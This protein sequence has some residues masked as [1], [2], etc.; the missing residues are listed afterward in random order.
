MSYCRWS[1]DAFKSD[2]YVY[3]H[4]GGYWAIHVAGSRYVGDV[5]TL[6][7]P[8]DAK[9]P[10]QVEAFKASYDAQRKFF[11]A[12]AATAL[13]NLPHAGETFQEPT[14]GACADRI[15]ELV[16]L[17]YHVPAGVVEELRAEQAGLAA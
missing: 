15:E 2:L 10:A 6:A 13:I 3:E 8:T 14:P 5:P 17:G 11:D 7:Y 1:S 16:A 4:V 9:D 12:G